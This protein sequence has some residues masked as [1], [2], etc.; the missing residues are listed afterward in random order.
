MLSK[1]NKLNFKKLG[2]EP[3]WVLKTQQS[4][5]C[6]ALV[7]KRRISELKRRKMSK[8]ETL[9]KEKKKEQTFRLKIHIDTLF[10]S[11]WPNFF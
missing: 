3:Q 5:F 8:Y 1:I 4:S 2:W 7:L 6:G 9:E 10:C 11:V